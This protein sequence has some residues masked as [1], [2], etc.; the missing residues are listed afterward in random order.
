MILEAIFKKNFDRC[1][2]FLNLGSRLEI[3]CFNAE[4]RLAVEYDGIQHRLTRS[5]K[6]LV[7]VDSHL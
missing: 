4:L 1:R 3:D 5:R 6:R 2:P 7:E